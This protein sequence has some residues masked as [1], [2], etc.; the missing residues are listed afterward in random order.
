MMEAGFSLKDSTVAILGLGLM[1]GSLA[2]ALRGHCRAV[3]ASDPNPEPLDAACRAGIVDRADRDPAK[4]LAGADI[5]ILAAPVPGILELLNGLPA[6]MAGG[7]IVL[8]IGSSKRVIVDAM[9]RLP[10]R[11]DPIGGHPLC[12]K[13]K[14]SFENADA[15]LY[16]GSSF[17]L[18]PLERTTD[19]ALSAAHQIIEAIG[20]N[21][22][23]L[24]AARHDWMLASTSHMPYLLSSALALA[25]RR[26]CAPLAGPGF[27]ST[28]RLAGTPSSMML[29]VLQTNRDNVLDAVH[30]LQ[31][32]LASIESLLASEDL[33]QLET[34][35][36]EAQSRYQELVQ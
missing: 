33:A 17:L 5:A 35:L 14:L 4:V 10:E 19:R 20:A 28:S 12:G 36:N 6:L 27:R 30:S 23:C 25:S 16:Q 7:C 2:M 9:G 15:G 26:E 29:G 1:G 3:T 31:K 34:V 11:F 18:T 8:D 22:I 32:Q 21:P 13:E 24:D